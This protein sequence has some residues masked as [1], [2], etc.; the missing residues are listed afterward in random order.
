MSAGH[1]HDRGVVYVATQ[2]DNYVEDA[3]LSADSIK[4]RYPDLSITLFTDRLSH[5]LCA[6]DRFDHV[7]CAAE[8]PDFHLGTVVDHA[9]RWSEGQLS[10]LLSLRRTPYRQTLHL[11]TDTKLVTDELMSLF[12]LLDD[13]DVGMTECSMDDS[14]SRL[15]YGRPMFNAGLI[16]Y[17]RN[18]LTWD[19][20]QEW[21]EL[22]ERNFRWASA[23]PLPRLASLR[24]LSDEGIRRKLMCMDQISLVEILSPETNKFNLKLKI[25]DGSWLYRGS[26]LQEQKATPRILH[27]RRSDLEL[28]NAI[29]RAL[30]RMS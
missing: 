27:I 24:H 20:L 5:P 26:Q 3:F 12:D 1:Q 2:V 14:Y 30:A 25:L 4:E 8:V 22:S 23:N 7:E 16:L 19:W 17:R 13:I 10:R 29:H 6:T 28:E 11:D 15:E 9:P 18:D 21:A